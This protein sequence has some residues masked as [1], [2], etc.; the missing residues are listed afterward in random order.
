MESLRRRDAMPDAAKL[1][2]AGRLVGQTRHPEGLRAVLSG[3]FRLPVEVVEWIGHWIAL[4][5]NCRLRLGQSPTSGVLGISATIGDR[6]W[7][8]QHKFRIVLG[9]VDLA[10]YQRLLPGGDS[11]QRLVAL[12]RNYL[13]DEL[14][15]DVKLILKA[16]EVPPIQLGM[17]GQL[18]WTTW[19]GGAERRQD[20]DD[21]CLV[22]LAN[23]ALAS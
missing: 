23:S 21:L 13:G 11:L 3:F 16:A 17:L 20:A 19:L 7:N 12:V 14:L 2:Y 5:A 10:N 22:P 18:G 15:W 8:C 1:Y 6:I 9:P 4:P